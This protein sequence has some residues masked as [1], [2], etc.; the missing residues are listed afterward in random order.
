MSPSSVLKCIWAAPVT[1]TIQESSKC[2][3]AD[4]VAISHDPTPNIS[5]KFEAGNVTSLRTAH[6]NMV[7]SSSP[8]STPKLPISSQRSGFAWKQRPNPHVL[9][10]T[11][12]SP[13]RPDQAYRRMDEGTKRPRALLLEQN[14][15]HTMLIFQRKALENREQLLGENGTLGAPRPGS[16]LGP[17]LLLTPGSFLAPGLRRPPSYP[18]SSLKLAVSLR[19]IPEPCSGDILPSLSAPLWPL[20]M[21]LQDTD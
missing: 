12:I 2:Q 19:T 17:V 7:I 4:V 14:R 18:L 15:Q 5:C 9:G 11:H 8:F 6:Y 21:G 16:F 10:P 20:T 3:S 13:H 1:T